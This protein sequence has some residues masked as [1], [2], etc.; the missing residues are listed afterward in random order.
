MMGKCKRQASDEQEREGSARSQASD[1][2]EGRSRRVVGKSERHATDGGV[3]EAG[4]SKRQACGG[5]E[6]ETGE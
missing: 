1:E 6:Q 3:Q 5:V 4:E 2:G